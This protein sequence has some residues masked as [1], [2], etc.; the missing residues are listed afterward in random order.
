MATVTGLNSFTAGTPAKASEV[1]ANFS[2]VKSFIEGLSTGVNID[3]STISTTKIADYN[4][5][6]I[7]IANGS[8]TSDKIL[9]GTIVAEDIA[10]GA[11]TSD[12]IL[13]L[14]IATGD[15]A[16]DAITSDKILD[17]TII[18]SN[19]A[20]A[21]QAFLV[22][23]GTISAYAGATAPDGWLL[24]DGTSTTGKPLLAAIVGVTTPDLRG[25][26]LV[27]KSASAP[28]NGALLTKFGSTTSTA[29]HSHTLTLTETP[30]GGLSTV[31]TTAGSGIV[32][33]SSNSSSATTSESSVGVAHGNVQ[34]SALVTYIIKHD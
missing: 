4:V 18:I 13:D 20:T 22:P 21:L 28:F 19:L 15:I 29:L 23:I 5:T 11:I 1:N 12:K 9:N 2:I 26:T 6:N 8:I 30:S 32:A 17:N 16:N 34:P 33:T 14:T 7:K 27:G 24:C 10:T 25:H 3:A 31:A